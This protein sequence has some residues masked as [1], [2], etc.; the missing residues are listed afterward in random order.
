MQKLRL[1]L[2]AT[3]ALVAFAVGGV[4]IARWLDV[5][6]AG[7]MRAQ[8]TPVPAIGGA[9][10]LVDTEGRRVSDADL[11]GKPAAMFFGF[12]HCP[13]VCPTTLVE[14]SG[15]LKALGPDAEKL[16][17]VF[18]SVD[19]ERDTPELLKAYLSSFDARITGL[20]GTVAEVD[21]IKKAY[22]VFARKVP[23]GATY[24]VDHSASVYLMDADGRFTGTIAWQEAP[25]SA[26]AKLRR[27]VGG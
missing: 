4:M 7:G 15:W 2:W 11:K 16:R 24:T 19:P 18:V 6:L 27:L 21:A 5:D 10:S 25:E 13:D 23:Q 12:T 1:L 26:L 9:F 17:V 8:V 20:T 14:A 22:R 3:V